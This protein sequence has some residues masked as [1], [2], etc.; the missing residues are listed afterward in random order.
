MYMATRKEAISV[1]LV[2]TITKTKSISKGIFILVISAHRKLITIAIG[3]L[4]NKLP[5]H[6]YMFTVHEHGQF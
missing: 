4:P 5:M 1:V 6:H 3:R 2:I